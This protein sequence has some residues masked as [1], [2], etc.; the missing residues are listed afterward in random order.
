MFQQPEIST[1]FADFDEL[2]NERSIL[3][4]SGETYQPDR[5]VVK[6]NETF[7]LDYKTGQRESKHQKQLQNYQ[8]ILL[9]MGYNNVKSYLLYLKEKELVAI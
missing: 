2:K 4:P 8:N 3:L 7:I 1:F 5:V 6:N 9:Q